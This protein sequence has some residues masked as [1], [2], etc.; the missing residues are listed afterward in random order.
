MEFMDFNANTW[1]FLSSVAVVGYFLKDLFK[2]FYDLE[3][4]VEN[5]IVKYSSEFGKLQGRVGAID[6]KTTQELKRIEELMQVNFKNY[7]DKV[8][9][10]IRMLER[11]NQER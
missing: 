1:L 5:T 3:N 7:G 2:R 10:V 9:E 4:K 6:L 8:E 11:I